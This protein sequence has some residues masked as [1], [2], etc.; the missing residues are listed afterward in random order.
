MAKAKKGLSARCG[1][2]DGGL[3]WRINDEIQS[4][5]LTGNPG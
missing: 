5:D 3:P 2:T 4:R 1:Y